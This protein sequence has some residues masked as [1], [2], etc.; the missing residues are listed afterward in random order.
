MGQLLIK[1]RSE[2]INRGR[3]IRL[4]LNEQEIGSIENGETKK[5][6]LK[7]DSYNLIARIDWCGSQVLNFKLNEGEIKK[8]ELSGF[9]KNKWIVPTLLLAQVVLLLAPQLIEIN[10]YLMIAYSFLLLIYI[11]YPITFGRNRYLKL[12]RSN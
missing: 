9:S 3:N 10:E 5:F 1:R 12:K 11:F 4:Y 2:W 6:E 8:I 7:P